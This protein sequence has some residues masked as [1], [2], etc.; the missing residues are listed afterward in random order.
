LNKEWSLISKK[1]T[2]K[3]KDALKQ[4]VIAKEGDFYF[5]LPEHEDILRQELIHNISHIILQNDIDKRDLVLLIKDE[6]NLK[7]GVEEDEEA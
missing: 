4:I 3:D 5:Y 1:K 7:F 6:I 2:I